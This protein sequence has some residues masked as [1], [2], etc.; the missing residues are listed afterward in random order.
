M[1][2]REGAFQMGRVKGRR[3]LF[4]N[5]KYESAEERTPAYRRPGNADGGTRAFLG[6]QPF[7][8]AG[9]L[10]LEG[11]SGP[12]AW[13]GKSGPSKWRYRMRSRVISLRRKAP[14]IAIVSRSSSPTFSA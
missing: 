7:A 10:R 11:K 12:S 6:R 1:R 5:R 9:T 4:G 2:R 13:A 14:V 8:R 3:A